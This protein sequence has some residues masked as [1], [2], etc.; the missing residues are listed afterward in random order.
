M[1]FEDDQEERYN[2]S[3]NFVRKQKIVLW[4]THSVAFYANIFGHIHSAPMDK[5]SRMNKLTNLKHVRKQYG[6]LILPPPE[7]AVSEEPDR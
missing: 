1:V 2:T 6:L 7:L 3:A 4:T 5:G